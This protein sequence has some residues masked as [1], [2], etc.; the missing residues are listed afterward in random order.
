MENTNIA[1]NT[2]ISFI[3]HSLEEL[4][5]KGYDT[6]L[7]I[8]EYIKNY[9]NMLY[10]SY[11]SDY[12]NSIMAYL[13]DYKLYKDNFSSLFSKISLVLTTISEWIKDKSSYLH[14]NVMLSVFEFYYEFLKVN[15]K[16]YLKFDELKEIIRF[17]LILLMNQFLTY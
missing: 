14:Y 1:I 11:S 12:L 16:T 5:N 13:T 7:P 15:V 17:I 2:A 3:V 8:I 4:K 9:Q 10:K 6:L